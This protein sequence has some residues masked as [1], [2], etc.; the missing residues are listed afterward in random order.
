MRKV[1]GEKLLL[2]VSLFLSVFISSGCD[3]T[4]GGWGEWDGDVI[5]R[6]QSPDKEVDALI[7]EGSFGATTGFSYRVFLVPSGAEFDKRSALF[8]KKN[9]VLI[10]GDAQ[11]LT[12][13]WKDARKLQITYNSARIFHYS[14]FA[15]FSDSGRPTKHLDINLIE[16]LSK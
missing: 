15:E 1:K 6:E 5:S 8:D 7:V 10:A 3:Y 2:A 11:K 13:V 4:V 9:A 12:T 14:N 16:K